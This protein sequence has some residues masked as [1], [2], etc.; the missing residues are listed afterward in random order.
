M[1]DLQ[2]N[3]LE[4]IYDDPDHKCPLEYVVW[5]FRWNTEISLQSKQVINSHNH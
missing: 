3:Q 2:D 1:E 5:S 4:I